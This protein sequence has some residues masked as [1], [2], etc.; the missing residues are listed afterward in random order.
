MSVVAL[1][2]HYLAVSLC[3]AYMW[4]SSSMSLFVRWSSSLFGASD[5]VFAVFLVSLVVD[6]LSESASPS[7]S[8]MALRR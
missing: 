8:S 2:G 6:V 3:V 7:L 5:C 1:L 4:R